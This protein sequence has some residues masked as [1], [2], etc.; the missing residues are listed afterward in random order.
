MDGGGAHDRRT[1]SDVRG[2]E[3]GDVEDPGTDGEEWEPDDD[4]QITLPH[5]TYTLFSFFL[6][7]PAKGCGRQ[8]AFFS[9]STFINFLMPLL[10]HYA[11]LGILT[12]YLT[13]LDYDASEVKT[14]KLL[15][16][17]SELVFVSFVC[18]DFRDCRNGK[19]DFGVPISPSLR[20]MRTKYNAEKKRKEIVSA[21]TRPAKVFTFAITI[22]PKFAF[23]MFLLIWGS[24]LVLL[25][26]AN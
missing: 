10:I 24:K 25:S 21:L 26:P 23:A 3:S 19:M 15:V 2:W 22:V 5:N 4:N 7:G 18:A 20:P 13:Q 14:D 1:M 17:V 16:A 6:C 9:C 11:I 8:L 12:F